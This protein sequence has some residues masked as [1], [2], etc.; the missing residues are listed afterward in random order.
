MRRDPE[1]DST[2]WMYTG[3]EGIMDKEGYLK[4][5]VNLSINKISTLGLIFMTVVGRRKVSKL[6]EI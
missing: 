1:D 2:V 6:C 5:K 3:D 4:S